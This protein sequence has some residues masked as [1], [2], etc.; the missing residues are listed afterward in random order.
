METRNFCV[1]SKAACRVRILIRGIDLETGDA[2]IG[3]CV[4][5]V[6]AEGGREERSR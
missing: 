3:V 1:E 4:V 5:E 6:R 2:K